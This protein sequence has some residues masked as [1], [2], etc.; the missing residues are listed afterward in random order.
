MIE[1]IIKKGKQGK[2]RHHHKQKRDIIDAVFE[3]LDNGYVVEIYNDINDKSPLVLSN[4]KDT[5]IIS[6]KKKTYK[7]M[8][9]DMEKKIVRIY[10]H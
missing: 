3:F 6:E 9:K 1:R 10:L 7:R 4:W 5:F 8:E 2:N